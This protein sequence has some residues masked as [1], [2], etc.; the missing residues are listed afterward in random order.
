[1]S[2]KSFESVKRPRRSNSS[3]A[4]FSKS[5]E[6][7][8]LNSKVELSF[9][10]SEA[11]WKMCVTGTDEFTTTD[12]RIVY[13][14]LLRAYHLRSSGSSLLKW[15]SSHPLHESRMSEALPPT[16]HGYPECVYTDKEIRDT[17]DILANDYARKDLVIAVIEITG[18]VLET[19]KILLTRFGSELSEKERDSIL[20]KQRVSRNLYV[21]AQVKYFEMSLQECYGLSSREETIRHYI[22]QLTTDIKKFEADL[23]APYKKIN[24][25]TVL[26]NG[27]NLEGLDLSR[28]EVKPDR[29]SMALGI[30]RLGSSD[31]LTI[32]HAQRLQQVREKSWTELP[33][34]SHSL[35]PK[36]TEYHKAEKNTGVLETLIPQ[37]S[38]ENKSEIPDN[39]LIMLAFEAL[40][41]ENILLLS[42]LLDPINDYEKASY[43]LLQKMYEINLVKLKKIE[44]ELLIL[45][46]QIDILK[47]FYDPSSRATLEETRIILNSVAEQ[48]LRNFLSEIRAELAVT[49][50]KR[51]V[52]I[53]DHQFN[54]PNDQENYLKLYQLKLAKVVGQ[55][56]VQWSEI[57]N[58]WKGS[59]ASDRDLFLSALIDRREQLLDK[60][61]Q[62]TLSIISD[63]QKKLEY[64][65]K[66]KDTIEK[67]K[68]LLYC[69][70]KAVAAFL[71]IDFQNVQQVARVLSTNLS[72]NCSDPSTENTLLFQALQ[73]KKIKMVD[74][75]L[76]HHA[77]IFKT[78]SDNESALKYS[79]SME[80]EPMYFQRLC[81]HLSSS[82]M[83]ELISPS[84]Y[85]FILQSEILFNII[86]KING[87]KTRL[88]ECLS[89]ILREEK[90][91]QPLEM[92]VFKQLQVLQKLV[93]VEVY[94]FL[95][96]AADKLVPDL[97]RLQLSEII[98]RYE[99]GHPIQ[100]TH[101]F[102]KIGEFI[103]ELKS[104]VSEDF[105]REKY[106][107]KRYVVESP[108]RLQHELLVDANSFILSPLLEHRLSEGHSPRRKATKDELTVSAETVVRV[109]RASFLVRSPRALP[110][111]TSSSMGELPA[112]PS[113]FKH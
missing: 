97:L 99:E 53:G 65:W 23:E 34:Q 2:R 14:R 11:L 16:V 1:M 71:K 32:E 64:K 41:K 21:K 29:L 68:H 104:S 42:F 35:L 72:V 31:K 18:E 52:W 77:C 55:Y 89:H 10:L 45:N 74:F 19:I 60:I 13:P 73:S 6:K 103:T 107:Y 69:N 58:L 111:S 25:D 8:K 85:E 78:N 26:L 62:L 30:F 87:L 43:R 36:N 9:Q 3:P 105:L 28:V 94:E 33:E 15:P 82:K 84:C 22:S 95:F 20:G 109:R 49:R 50:F 108:S 113:D 12:K 4:L 67:K 46:T 51:S 91:L 79:L 7:L 48:S 5:D 54:L 56:H 86:K 37:K 106:K 88:D 90:E 112:L 40:S 100:S 66:Q 83:E 61:K 80:G 63:S 81:E 47:N 17:F 75:L 92:V 27:V 38:F 102:K 98:T 59:D 24:L 96:N 76:M 70:E 57:V 39:P 93:F 44:L 110:G 101:L